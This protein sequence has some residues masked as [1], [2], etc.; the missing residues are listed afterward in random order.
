MPEAEGDLPDTG[1]SGPCLFESYL[2]TPLPFPGRLALGGT[3]DDPVPAW[4]APALPEGGLGVELDPPHPAD[5]SNDDMTAVAVRKRRRKYG[6]DDMIS[7]SG[8][9]T[10]IGAGA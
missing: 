2:G 1:G 10:Y 4:P 6:P 3:F 5:Q 7:A 9:N 8:G